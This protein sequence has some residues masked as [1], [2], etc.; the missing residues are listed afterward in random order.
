MAGMGHVV[1]GWLGGQQW[2]AGHNG[3]REAL[4]QDEDGA[5]RRVL[6]AA[7]QHLQY[8]SEG[9][10]RLELRGKKTPRV[11]W[12]TASG[13]FWSLGALSVLLVP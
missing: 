3:G 9:G 5:A 7:L 13:L 4:L 12:E 1:A 11:K 8:S 10:W 6:G 2:M